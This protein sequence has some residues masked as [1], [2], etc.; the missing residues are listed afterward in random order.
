M[1]KSGHDHRI[2]TARYPQRAPA[3]DTP[4]PDRIPK[5]GAEFSP[6]PG[7]HVDLVSFGLSGADL[8]RRMEGVSKSLER[9][10]DVHRHFADEDKSR[11]VALGLKSTHQRRSQ[12]TSAKSAVAG[13]RSRQHTPEHSM[14]LVNAK[15]TFTHTENKFGHAHVRTL[16]V[17][18][19]VLGRL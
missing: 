9:P 4:N 10:Q 18:T 5:D 13:R 16:S 3:S 7:R 19:Q 6:R 12:A 14:K 17:S 15:R 11:E 2:E 8:T 1:S